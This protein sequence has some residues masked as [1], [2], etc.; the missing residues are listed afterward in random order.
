R[1]VVAGLRKISCANLLE[2][3]TVLEYGQHNSRASP[4]NSNS[5]SSRSHA[6]FVIELKRFSTRHPEMERESSSLQ[7]VDLAGS[8]RARNTQTTGERLVEACSINRSLMCLGQCLQLQSQS[9][10]STTSASMIVRQSK[11]T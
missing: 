5:V 7:I 8:E 11:L 9:S 4:T 1:K 2:A 6:F 3:L 10:M